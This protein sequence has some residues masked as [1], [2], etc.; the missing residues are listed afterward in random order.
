MATASRRATRRGPRNALYF[1]EG[2][3]RLAASPFAGQADVVT[4]SFPWGSLLRG[5]LGLDLAALAGV[6]SL[7]RPGRQLRVLASVVPSDGVAGM[8][9]LD[10]SSAPAIR[11]AWRASGLDLT[12]FRP[13][14]T[15]DI[16]QSHS[17][18]ARRLG[19]ADSRT[20]WVL[21]GYR[22]PAVLHSE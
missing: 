18:W 7:I 3:E 19:G 12:S 14:T 4:V 11:A 2:A 16:A 15:M 17:T 13:A 1:A 5:V 6:A 10:D 21:E 22:P 9:C 8:D 20:V